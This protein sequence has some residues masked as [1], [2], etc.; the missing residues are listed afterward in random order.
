MMPYLTVAEGKRIIMRKIVSFCFLYL[1]FSLSTNA[2]AGSENHGDIS[3]HFQKKLDI[4]NTFLAENHEKAIKDP[5]LLI[6]FVNK[7]LL[8]VWSAKNTIRAMLGAKRWQQLSPADSD[9]LIHAYEN[10]IRRYLFEV[11]QRYQGQNAVV[12]SVRLNSKANKGWLRV[13]LH[14]PSLPDFDVDLKIYHDGATAT[15][16]VYDFSFQGISFVRM[17]RGFF[18]NTFDNEGV[19]GIIASLEQKNRKFKQRLMA[20]NNEQ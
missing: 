3:T 6:E 14:S 20:A 2:L 10:T 7:E 8:T 1:F 5:Q 16:T 15:W 12:S 4:I 11:L 9:N 17:K 18:R 13:T 19:S